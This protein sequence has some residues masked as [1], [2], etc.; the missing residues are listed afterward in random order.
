MK[1]LNQYENALGKIHARLSDKE[2]ARF[3]FVSRRFIETL[4]AWRVN[5]IVS[6]AEMLAVLAEY[7]D[8][9]HSVDAIL[10]APD[11]DGETR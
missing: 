1:L 10:A 8:L 3:E 11:D 5:K 7:A 9:M 2:K 4:H 6:D